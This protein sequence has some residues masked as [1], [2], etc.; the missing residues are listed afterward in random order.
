[1]LVGEKVAS[2]AMLY[3]EVWDGIAPLSAL[4]YTL[5]DYLFGRSQLIYQILAYFTVCFQVFVFNRFLLT[6]RAYT[7]N[8]YLP[9]FLYALLAS[10]CYD[11][12]TLTPF[13]MGMTFILLA[14]NNIFSHIEV[15]AKRDEDILNIG[16]YIGIA[17]VI[18]LPY[19]IFAICTLV[20]FTFFT[21]TV[22]RRYALMTFGFLLPVIVA[23]G[24]FYLTDRLDDF[25]FSFLAPFT[26]IEKVWYI[27]LKNTL[28][29]FVAPIAFFL[30][31]FVRIIQGARLTNYQNR[32]TQTM[33]VWLV[34]GVLFV[35]LSDSNSPNVYTVLVAPFAF[36]IA[37]YY[38]AKKRG[39]F[40]ELSFLLFFLLIASTS[41]M[42]H[43]PSFLKNYFS[44]TEY[45]IDSNENQNLKS[46]KVLVLD[47]N[48]GAYYHSEMSTPFLNWQLSEGVFTNLNYYDNLTTIYDGINNDR[49][50]VILDPNGLMDNVIS[51]IPLLAKIYDKRLDGNYY[52]KSSN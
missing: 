18:Y 17:T 5:I 3:S 20:I 34:F 29:I 2:G 10:T 52:L 16:L 27:N 47:D 50:D 35:V 14:L 22:P 37:H 25:L 28:I 9:G 6:S 23:V 19:C 43:Y 21:G 24:Y 44:D 39:V 36:Y 7:E 15:R 46:K 51:K 30:L 8:T 31:S 11:M 49:P 33:L 42:S 4:V 13:L 26:E 1:M 12:N 45:L 48:L 32:L 41:V 40:A 38:L